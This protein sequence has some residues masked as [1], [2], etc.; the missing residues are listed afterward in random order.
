M[1]RA[2]GG[3]E[4][5][6]GRESELDTLANALA[7]ARDGRPAIVLVHGVAGVGK[8]RFARVVCESAPDVDVL[9]ASGE[10]GESALGFG[11]LDQILRAAR[12]PGTFGADGA[13]TEPTEAGRRLL[14]VLAAGAAE[15]PVVLVV[16]DVHWAD[17]ASMLTLTFVLRRLRHEQV[18]TI[19]TCRDENLD[20]LNDG[21]R[22]V[23]TAPGVVDVA[24]TGLGR[25][26]LVMLAKSLGTPLDP[27]TALRLAQHTEGNPLFARAMLSEW[28]ADVLASMDEADPLPAP[29]AF[30]AGVATRL[31]ACARSSVALAEAAAVLGLNADLAAV[32]AVAGV[33]DAA[34]ALDELERAGLLVSED[35][36]QTVRFTHPLVQAAI[37][38]GLTWQRRSDLHA[39][40]SRAPLA[41]HDRLRHRI[42]STIGHDD[43]LAA[44]AS[45]AAEREAARG[46]HDVAA[47]LHLAARRLT[48]SESNAGA[49][50]CAGV[51][52]H[53]LA[54]DLATA[55]GYEADLQA[56]H[57]DPRAGYL[58]GLLAAI[59]G[60]RAGGM[61]LF[62]R[63]YDNATRGGDEMTAA[64][65]AL[66]LGVVAL[67]EG[68]G[69]DA[70]GWMEHVL[71]A[72]Q[73]G[74]DLGMANL[75]KALGLG[76]NGRAADWSRLYADV[77]DGGGP[78]DAARVGRL[79]G[80]GLL[81]MW[82]G[83]L[84]GSVGDLDRTLRMAVGTG[85]FYL[86]V[87]AL[88]YLAEAEYRLGEWD[89]S[90][91]HA[92]LAGSLADDSDEVWTQGLAHAV[93]VKVAA[94]RGEWQRAQDHLTRAEVAATTLGD[95]ANRLSVETSRARLAQAQGQYG[96]GMRAAARLAEPEALAP[97][98]WNQSIQPWALLGA[99]AGLLGGDPAFAEGL[100]ARAHE[101]TPPGN[102]VVVA[103]ER[104]LDLLAA[105][106]RGDATAVSGRCEEA[107]AAIGSGEA[108]A[109]DAALIH[110]DVGA[111]LR[112][113]RRR[114]AAIESLS[115]ARE[116]LVALGAH[117]FLGRC[118]R[119][120][121]ATGVA[122]AD[123][124]DP[125]SVL[126]AQELAVVT[127][128]VAG[129]SNREIAA[130]LVV[131]VKTVEYHLRNVFAKL[132]VGSRAELVASWLRAGEA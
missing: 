132:G 90:V 40:A 77:P 58:R 92:E 41:D 76:L 20:Q 84:S 63:A 30:A 43:A 22:R 88:L 51:E 16:D 126:T 36:R 42:A 32:V 80:R 56:R 44:E 106:R 79:L 95:P 31:G 96:E 24:L 54:G 87:I 81:R 124:A 21:L 23:L 2:A 46:A 89:R 12:E 113:T 26:E 97:G 116:R 130:E 69:S 37:Y 48:T 57:D 118:N 5:F 10:P 67:N 102:P 11:V 60:D 117:P 131:S 82:C 107:L 6:V 47:R 121:A 27:S 123:H 45:A 49:A 29:R 120:L 34:A 62:E 73:A 114:R 122:V 100:L 50:L 104:R 8:T 70:V 119:E 86:R 7:A 75:V 1:R 94:G 15:R 108:H 38:R 55:R 105:S 71:S 74:V 66:Q 25:D 64:R 103:F 98:M 39:A 111:T 78:P 129:R 68:R 33:E 61:A 115:Q 18:L 53:V 93:A 99:E 9:W 85:P 4:D 109:L 14:D 83:D 72:G 13:S 59:G 35:R 19:F 3:G 65:V 28:E 101:R 127:L 91:T 128:V 110:L 112:R 17:P 52:E 125:R